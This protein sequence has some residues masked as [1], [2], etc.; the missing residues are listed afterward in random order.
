MGAGTS[1]RPVQLDSEEPVAL[2]PTK[3]FITEFQINFLITMVLFSRRKRG[4]LWGFLLL[5]K[6]RCST[7]ATKAKTN[8]SFMLNCD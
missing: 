4:I 6:K 5:S 2:P 8:S 3:E 1:Y 7:F